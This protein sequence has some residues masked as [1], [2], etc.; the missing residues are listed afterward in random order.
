MDFQSRDSH[1]NLL[2]KSETRRQ[3]TCGNIHLSINHS[4]PFFLLSLKVGLPSDMMFAIMTVNSPCFGTDMQE[5]PSDLS[6]LMF[7]FILNMTKA[8]LLK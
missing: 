3:N 6:F 4:A 8:Y 5:L 7:F 1:S 2:F